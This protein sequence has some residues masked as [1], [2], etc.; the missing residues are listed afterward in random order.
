MASVRIHSKCDETLD[1]DVV[2]R[3]LVRSDY[4][5]PC[6]MK[7]GVNSD[8]V[9]PESFSVYRKLRGGKWGQCLGVSQL[10]FDY[11]TAKGYIKISG[12]T[13]A[14]WVAT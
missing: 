5:R 12:H 2:I 10:Q 4:S 1:C 3:E 11:L 13:P 14:S 6:I 9:G 8:D 7:T